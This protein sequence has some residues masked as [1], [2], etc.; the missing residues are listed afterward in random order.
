MCTHN[1]PSNCQ[2]MLFSDSNWENE[3]WETWQAV[4]IHSSLKTRAVS[5]SWAIFFVTTKKG[6]LFSQIGNKDELPGSR[7]GVSDSLGQ[8]AQPSPSSRGP[9]DQ[10]MV[11]TVSR[12]TSSINIGRNSLHLDLFEVLYFPELPFSPWHPRPLSQV[13]WTFVCVRFYSPLYPRGQA[14]PTCG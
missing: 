12:D 11:S 14:R 8:P 1:H 6:Q 9:G 2:L 10:S 7:S 3:E 13:S 4:T 5:R